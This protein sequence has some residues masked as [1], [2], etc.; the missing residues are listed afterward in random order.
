MCAR[1]AMTLILFVSH[2]H[3]CEPFRSTHEHLL[4]SHWSRARPLHFWS[5]ET[6]IIHLVYHEWVTVWADFDEIAPFFLHAS[7]GL[8]GRAGD[9]RYVE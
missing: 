3:V 8:G 9:S 4:V 7:S 5:Y 6:L 1:Y 2:N